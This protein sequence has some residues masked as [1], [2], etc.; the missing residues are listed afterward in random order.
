MM[1]M[2]FRKQGVRDAEAAPAA[3]VGS[4]NVPASRAQQ[5]QQ[6]LLHA[7]WGPQAACMTVGEVAGGPAEGGEAV[8]ADD[9][10]VEH[11]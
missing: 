7:V 5:Q 6:Q 8:L 3:A 2:I 9:M 10:H 1:M 11:F 4:S